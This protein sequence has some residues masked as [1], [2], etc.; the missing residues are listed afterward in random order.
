[1]INMMND[2]KHSWNP[3]AAIIH[4]NK[5]QKIFV[6]VRVFKSDCLCF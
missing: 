2:E 4:G 6:Y 3:K 5:E 1:M